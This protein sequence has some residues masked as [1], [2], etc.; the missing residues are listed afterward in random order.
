M[1]LNCKVVAVLGA[2]LLVG[3]PALAQFRGPG[4]GSL[5]TNASVQN[6]LKMSDEQI[7]KAKEA[8]KA[9][10]AKF[11][12]QRPDKGASEEERAAFGKKVSEATTKALADILKPEQIKRLR[13][14]E[15]QQRGP[16]DA[17][18]QKELK[19]SDEQ[20]AKFK[21]IGEKAST[22]RRELFKD[23]KDNPKEAL[24]KMTKLGKE[25]VEKEIGVLSDAQKKQW[26]EMTG[27]AFEV[28]FEP[29]TKN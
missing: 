21:E 25:K 12:D 22:E 11:K 8:V 23:F 29:R 6:E 10:S 19:C 16:S 15:L 1:R 17:D 5:A 4:G 13:Q 18:A 28:K 26:K 14:I 2:A 24:E 9:V 7:E 27:D 3:G 20:K